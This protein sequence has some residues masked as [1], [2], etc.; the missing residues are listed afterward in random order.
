[1]SEGCISPR[2][3]Y[4]RERRATYVLR[5]RPGAASVCTWCTLT[6]TTFQSQASRVGLVGGSLFGGTYKPQRPPA[7]PYVRPRGHAGPQ[8]YTVLTLGGVVN[9]GWRED[10]T[11]SRVR[12]QQLPRRQPS[13]GH[14][15]HA[16]PNLAYPFRSGLGE[17]VLT[18][19]TTLNSQVSTYLAPICGSS[20]IQLR[21]VPS[22]GP[23]PY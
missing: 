18:P 3:S 4:A 21:Q 16:P 14:M 10:G 13:E 12:C 6:Y 15:P 2:P 20:E 8:I 9:H 1:M 5:D 19:M 11:G 7:Q 17:L 23:T 22:G